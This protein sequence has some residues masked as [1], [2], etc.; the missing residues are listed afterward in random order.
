MTAADMIFQRLLERI[1]HTK[2]TM[3]TTP[4][5]EMIFQ[6]LLEQIGAHRGRGLVFAA[7]GSADIILAKT[8]AACLVGRG[9]LRVDL[10]QPLDC[11][12]MSEMGLLASA[13]KLYALEAEDSLEPESVLRHHTSVPAS[14]HPSSSRGKGLNISS[15][16]EWEHGN[17]YVCAAH[18][19]GLSSLARRCE[20]DAPY[21][22]FAIGVDGGGD[23]LTHGDDEFDRIVLAGFRSSWLPSRPLLLVSM[24]LGAD[25]GSA[26]AEF[27][28]VALPGWKPV[29]S[30]EVDRAFADSLQMELKR[31]SLWHHSPASW[32]S[33]DPEW[34]YGFKVGQIIAHAVRG[35]CP[36]R[37]PGADAD[38]VMFPR[39]RELKLMKRSL[40]RE[41]RIFRSDVSR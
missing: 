19:D 25:G 17:R 4:A 21:Y 7:G 16:I 27:D 11:R 35:E 10:A 38:A 36:F 22:E 41:A 9:C 1:R 39:R 34:S 15:S 8:I 33:D 29:A 40:L 28:D 37:V 14:L 5:A 13:G 20:G 31:L 30:M 24:G 2:G 3:T 6:R 12:N 26:P 23:V 18:G 32:T